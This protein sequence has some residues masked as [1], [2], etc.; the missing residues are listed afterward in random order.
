MRSRWSLVA[1][2]LL[3]G[4]G[5]GG[6]D[7]AGAWSITTEGGTF[8]SPDTVVTLIVPPNA[9]STT[10]DVRV[11]ALA[12]TPAAPTGYA[13]LPLSGYDYSTT[14]FSIPATLQISYGSV[15]LTTDQ[16]ATIKLFT[17]APGTTTWTAVPTTIDTG[18]DLATVQLTTLTRAAL[19]YKVTP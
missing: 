14:N 7:T 15:Q 17:Q 18:N 19:F 10:T 3:V 4:C 13:Y 9:V 2:L 1:V 16:A 11:T 6:G 12:G 8:Q 5:G